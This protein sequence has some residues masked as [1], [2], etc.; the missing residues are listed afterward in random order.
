LAR[1]GF[2]R[3]PKSPLLSPWADTAKIMHFNG[4]YKPWRMPRHRR[5]GQSPKALCGEAMTDCAEHWWKYM[6]VRTHRR[7]SPSKEEEAEDA[8]K[9][10]S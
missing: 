8:S 10:D 2:G 1:I 9:G 3:P 7:L 4:K 5:K 6:S